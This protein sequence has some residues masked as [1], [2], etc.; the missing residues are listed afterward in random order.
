[1][2]S[3]Y[4]SDCLIILSLFYCIFVFIGSVLVPVSNRGTFSAFNSIKSCGAIPPAIGGRM[5]IVNTEKR[6][7]PGC[8]ERQPASYDT[9]PHCALSLSLLNPLLTS[10]PPPLCPTG[11]QFHG[12]L[13]PRLVAARVQIIPVLPSR[14]PPEEV[15][16]HSWPLLILWCLSRGPGTARA[17]Q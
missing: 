9:R 14:G 3:G 4:V 16:R 1:M 12:A 5:V 15:S 2:G 10:P 13:L 11:G 6:V 8:P 17:R 7:A